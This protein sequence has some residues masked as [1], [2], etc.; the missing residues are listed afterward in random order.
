METLWIEAPTM[1]RCL[2]AYVYPPA[3]INA[4]QTVVD[5]R[6]EL[7][8]SH[9]DKDDL[10]TMTNAMTSMWKFDRLAFRQAGSHSTSSSGDS[11][12]VDAALV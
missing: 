7:R 8:T 2:R 3:A 11:L 6:R 4:S 12:P 10:G 9:P 5:P 1:K